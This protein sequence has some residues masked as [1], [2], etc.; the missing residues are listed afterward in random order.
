MFTY[1][2]LDSTP[3]I[4]AAVAAGLARHRRRLGLAES[5]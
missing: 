4:A 3:V 2:P 5:G 1:E